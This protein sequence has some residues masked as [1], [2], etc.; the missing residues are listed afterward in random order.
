MV[1]SR[2]KVFRGHLWSFVYLRL[3]EAAEHFIELHKRRRK[4]N[5]KLT[6]GSDTCWFIFNL[7]LIQCVGCL[8]ETLLSIVLKLQLSVVLKS[9]ASWTKLG[10]SYCAFVLSGI[11]NKFKIQVKTSADDNTL[12]KLCSVTVFKP[13]QRMNYYQNTSLSVR[14][15]FT[16]LH[17][18]HSNFTAVCF[19]FSLLSDSNSDSG[20]CRKLQAKTDEMVKAD[21]AKANNGHKTTQWMRLDIT[22]FL[23]MSFETFLK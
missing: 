21:T 5:L 12:P 10:K 19:P 18:N 9:Q 13:T 11:N 15:I 17:I 14:S 16:N 2:I 23:H 6:D 20:K 8:S 4:S 1:I 3:Y 7:F 22:N